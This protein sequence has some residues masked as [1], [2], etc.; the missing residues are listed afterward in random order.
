MNEFLVAQRIKDKKQKDFETKQWQ[1]QISRLNNDVQIFFIINVLKKNY[2][3][4]FRE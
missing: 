4:Y 2:Y 3:S 1:D